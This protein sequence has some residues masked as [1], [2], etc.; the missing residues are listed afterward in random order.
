[1]KQAAW[2]VLVFAI[3]QA[4]LA[5]TTGNDTSYTVQGTTPGRE[6]VLR[7]Q[8]EV[9]HPPVLPYRIR[10]VPHWQYVYA[11]HTY[12]LHVPT[13][14]TSRMFTHLESRSVFI[15][16]DRYLGEDWMGHWVAHELGHL[17]TKSAREEDA[18]KAAAEYR[19]RLK[20]E[21]EAGAR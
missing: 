6:A 21:H 9:M 17:A 2:L 4:G 15:D 16:E 11:A 20:S 8:I 1:V 14:M 18:E 19:Q 13:G 5:Q 3:A 10:F 7:H 12:R